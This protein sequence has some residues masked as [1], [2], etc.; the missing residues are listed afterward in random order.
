MGK[1]IIITLKSS[2]SDLRNII[3]SLFKSDRKFTR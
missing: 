1:T 2:A 3:F